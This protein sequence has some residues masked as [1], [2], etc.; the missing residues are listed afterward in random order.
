MRISSRNSEGSPFRCSVCG[1]KGRVELSKPGMDAALSVVR[2][3]DLGRFGIAL[4]G[5][6]TLGRPRFDGP[7]TVDLGVVCWRCSCRGF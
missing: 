4:S 6:Y 7:D 5:G 2:F 3:L 1:F